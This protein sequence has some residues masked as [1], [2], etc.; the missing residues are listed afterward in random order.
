[1]EVTPFENTLD[2]IELE[3]KYLEAALERAAGSLLQLSGKL[4]LF[5]YKSFP[6]ST[7]EL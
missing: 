4:I 5:L 3:G 2:I 1:M 6:L 7:L